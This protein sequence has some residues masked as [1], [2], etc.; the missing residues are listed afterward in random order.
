MSFDMKSD[1]DALSQW[2][3]QT[4]DDLPY[5]TCSLFEGWQHGWL[6]QQFSP[7]S[8]FE[9]TQ[10]LFPGTIAYRVKQVHGNVVLGPSEMASPL[11]NDNLSDGD[12]VISQDSGQAVWVCT[13]D[14]TP[15]LIGDVRTGQAA[16]VHAG[17]RGTAQKIVTV[18]IDRLV[19][20]GSRLEDLR[21]GLGPAVSGESYQV[22]A[23]VGIETAMTI[24]PSVANL[25]EAAAIA[26]LL[27]L[28]N[29]PIL[30]DAEPGKVRM[31][32]R[33]V[34]ALQLEQLG[35]RPEQVA[36][37]PH[38]TY[39]DPV[40]FFSYRRETRKKAQWSGIVSR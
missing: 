2:Q 4:W 31:D 33:R 8:P 12:G 7:R 35:L 28:P 19:K 1:D 6:T 13:A 24:A 26:Q 20:S 27:A 32:V 37:A 25:S 15:V 34:N 18:A 9:I 10:N 14:C 40:N 39:G 17:W 38:C 29:S 11:H 30:P 3:W 36:I 5:L 23:A 21:V 22:T 16:A